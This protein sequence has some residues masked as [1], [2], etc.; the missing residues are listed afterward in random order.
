MYVTLYDGNI[1]PGVNMLLGMGKL[2]GTSN[3]EAIAAAGQDIQD[4]A[5]Q[6]S[7]RIVQLVS[8]V[9]PLQTARIWEPDLTI[10]PQRM[11]ANELDIQKRMRELEKSLGGILPPSPKIEEI[12]RR[13]EASQVKETTEEIN[14]SVHQN[15]VLRA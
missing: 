5:K 2:V 4:W 7:N 6:A 1:H 12:V 9:R 10:R 14:T 11:H 13:A 15:P 3:P 8:E